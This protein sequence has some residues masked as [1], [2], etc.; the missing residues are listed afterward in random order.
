L[1][2]R[3]LRVGKSSRFKIAFKELK[4]PRT[5]NADEDVRVL[6]AA[7][8]REFEAWIR[9]NPEQW[10]WSNKRWKDHELPGGT[11]S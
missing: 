6:T 2:G 7:I 4:V 11:Q 10:M 1:V 5:D 3:V 9:A 8:H